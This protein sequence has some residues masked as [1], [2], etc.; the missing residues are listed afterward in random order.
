METIPMFKNG[1]HENATICIFYYLRTG[2]ST[3]QQLPRVTLP[4][5]SS[6]GDNAVT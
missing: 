5:L 3:K 6:L 4:R 1:H 2:N